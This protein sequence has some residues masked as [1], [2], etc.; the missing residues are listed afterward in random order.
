[1]VIGKDFLKMFPVYGV[2]NHCSKTSA[3]SEEYSFY[4]DVAVEGAKTGERCQK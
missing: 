1:M 4:V 2:A 3:T